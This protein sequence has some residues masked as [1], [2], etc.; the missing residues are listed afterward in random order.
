MVMRGIG[1]D[2]LNASGGTT[3]KSEM[4]DHGPSLMNRETEYWTFSDRHDYYH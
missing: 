2:V 4:H 3:A 1:C